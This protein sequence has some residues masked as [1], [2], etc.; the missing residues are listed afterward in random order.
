MGNALGRLLDI[1][2]KGGGRQECAGAAPP[3]ETDTERISWRLLNHSQLPLLIM[4]MAA[5]I[6]SL[7]L[8]SPVFGKGY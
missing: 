4:L 7:C 6:P 3:V 8:T 5:I 2:R 1:G